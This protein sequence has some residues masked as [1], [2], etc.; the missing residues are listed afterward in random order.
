M[1]KSAVRLEHRTVANEDGVRAVYELLQQHP[2]DIENGD[3]FRAVLC[4]VSSTL[5]YLVVG[6]HHIAMDGFSWEI[7]FGELQRGYR[8]GSLQPVARQYST[9]ASKQRQES[10]N[11][12]LRSER[13][14]WRKEFSTLPPVLP[15]LPFATVSSRRPLKRYGLNRASHKV[16]SSITSLVMEQCRANKVSPFHFHLA[17]FRTLLHRLTGADDICIGMA[18]ANRMDSADTGVIG[19]L[20]NLLPLR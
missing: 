11:G 7:L 10:V 5:F 4:E 2:Y 19:F 13:N 9:W 18:D 14:F 17:S 1:R 6:Y 15:L 16:D 8:I 20:L 12:Q 3:T